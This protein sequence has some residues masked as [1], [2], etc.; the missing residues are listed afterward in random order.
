MGC[1]ASMKKYLKKMHWMAKAFIL[2]KMLERM[3]WPTRPLIIQRSFFSPPCSWDPRNPAN[4]VISS[5]AR[6]STW[7][8]CE[9]RIQK[10]EKKP[11]FNR[12]IM[13][14]KNLA[15]SRATINQHL[16]QRVLLFEPF[17]ASSSRTSKVTGVLGGTCH[18]F[19]QVLGLA[20]APR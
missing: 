6:L 13:K 15:S 19:L 11:K 7:N 5:V 12:N 20:L 17:L 14:T 2:L 10:W 1:K 16:A 8:K 18:P 3:Q 9:T 4:L